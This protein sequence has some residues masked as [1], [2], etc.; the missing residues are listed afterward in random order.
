M[1]ILLR[2]WY[3]ID[4]LFVTPAPT[5]APHKVSSKL[6]APNPLPATQAL[7]NKLLSKYGTGEIFSGQAE[8]SGI[9]YLEKNV[10]KTPAM[11]GLD[12]IEYSP[13]R[14]VSYLPICYKPSMLTRRK[15]Y[16]SVG[17][18]VEDA[19]TFD[20]R[21]GLVSFQWHWNAPA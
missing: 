9:S 14:A 18:S 11:V 16:G 5:P 7:F 4:A 13:T 20:A 2:G 1:L 8:L 17:V 10:G 21:G 19:Q 6:V 12:M 15:Q 3:F